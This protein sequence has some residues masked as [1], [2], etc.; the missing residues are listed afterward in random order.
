MKTQTI[1]FRFCQTVFD[2]LVISHFAG[3]VVSI[4]RCCSIPCG[5]LACKGDVKAATT[6]RDESDVESVEEAEVIGTQE[7]EELHPLQHMSKRLFEGVPR[8]SPSNIANVTDPLILIWRN[9]RT[10]TKPPRLSE[11]R[12]S[13]LMSSWLD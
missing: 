1:L 8:G 13:G 12:C 6:Y 4:P 10:T 2:D 9:C 5:A 11:K 7:F 3:R